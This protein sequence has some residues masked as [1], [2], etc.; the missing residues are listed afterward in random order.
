MKATDAYVRFLLSKPSNKN[1]IAQ[2]SWDKNWKIY[3]LRFFHNIYIWIFFQFISHDS[4]AIS[5]LFG[6]L[7]SRNGTYAS[8]AFISGVE[9]KNLPTRCGITA[10]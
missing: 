6:G 9:R 1:E 5:F 3:H 7:D 4:C 8:V 2:L 10:F